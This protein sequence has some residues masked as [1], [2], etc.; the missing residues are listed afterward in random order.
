MSASSRLLPVLVFIASPAFAQAEPP[1]EPAEPAPAAPAQTKVSERSEQEAAALIQRLPA[2]QQRTLKADDSE[3][4]ALWLPANRATAQGTVIL[5]PG[6]NETADW[7]KVVG[8]LRR[9]LPESGWNTLSLTLPDPLDPLTGYTIGTGPRASTTPPSADTSPETS[10]ASD[11]P[12]EP[13]DSNVGD[14]APADDPEPDVEAEPEASKIDPETRRK[15][16]ADRVFARIQAA[17]DSVSEQQPPY[18]VLVG[19]GTGAYWSARFANEQ[20]PASLTHVVMV[21]GT[22]PAGYPPALTN[23]AA[24]LKAG[25]ADVVTGTS[26]NERKVA[27]A[28]LQASKRES[29]PNYHQIR[30]G[31]LSADREVA[32]DQLVRRIRGWLD[33]H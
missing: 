26:E 17:I 10:P 19:N 15:A 1:A 18:V 4:L 25:V 3:F 6:N 20:Q 24:T 5:V 13:S 27:Q 14:A 16:H 28:R 9:T 12:A 29:H 32:Q 22:D 30:L 23:L 2:E 8:P 33:R 7:P 11:A 31:G 21:N